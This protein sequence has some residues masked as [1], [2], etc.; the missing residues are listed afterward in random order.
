MAEPR[1]LPQA[2][3]RG[4]SC[5]SSRVPPG[6]R[7]AARISRGVPELPR[8]SA[9]V[10]ELR[11]SRARGLQRMS[12]AERGA[13]PRPRTRESLRVFQ[14]GELGQGGPRASRRQGRAR[15][16]LQEGLSHC[17]RLNG[18]RL[19]RC[20]AS[21]PKRRDRT[22]AVRRVFGADGRPRDPR[23]SPIRGRGHS[24]RGRCEPTRASDARPSGGAGLADVSR[25]RSHRIH[26]SK[27]SR[28]LENP[29]GSEIAETRRQEEEG[30]P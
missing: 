4:M 9:R 17:L 2:F 3:R 15:G 16:P 26:S 14:T 23:A 7:R 5:L 1:D 6:S 29:R 27:A 21:R 20:L 18:I 30:R 10:P 24:L 19:A 22:A 25:G 13:R 28:H 12:R 8:R 11:P